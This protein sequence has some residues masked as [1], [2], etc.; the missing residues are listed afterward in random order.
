MESSVSLWPSTS[1]DAVKVGSS[2]LTAVWS[3]SPGVEPDDAELELSEDMSELEELS[4][5]LEPEAA[6]S[7]EPEVEALVSVFMVAEPVLAIEPTSS[8]SCAS[9]SEHAAIAPLAVIVAAES[10]SADARI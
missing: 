8:F 5:E 3:V 6:M 4:I 9:S 7:L 10:V 2:V 1:P